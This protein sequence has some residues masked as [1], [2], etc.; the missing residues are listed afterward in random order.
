[1][2]W[3]DLPDHKLIRIASQGHQDVEL[4]REALIKLEWMRDRA[5]LELARRGQHDPCL[6]APRTVTM[7]TDGRP[8]TYEEVRNGRG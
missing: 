1:M 5:R 2:E 7:S 6:R 8:I 3:N 4:A